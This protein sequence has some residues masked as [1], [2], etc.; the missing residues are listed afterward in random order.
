MRTCHKWL[1][2][3]EKCFW[4]GFTAVLSNESM[5]PWERK[6]LQLAT[7]L[8]NCSPVYTLIIVSFSCKFICTFFDLCFCSVRS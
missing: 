2:F 4:S 6:K 3:G 8:S 5:C 1:V 7:M